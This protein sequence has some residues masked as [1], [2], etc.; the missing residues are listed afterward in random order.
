MILGKWDGSR[1][2]AASAKSH[3]FSEGFCLQISVRMLLWYQLGSTCEERIE[4]H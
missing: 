3:L 4:G 1:S 2:H